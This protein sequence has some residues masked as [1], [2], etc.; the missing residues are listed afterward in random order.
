MIDDLQNQL[1]VAR[2][3][4]A[5]AQADALAKAQALALARRLGGKV[6]INTSNG[7]LVRWLLSQNN[8]NAHLPTSVKSR[9]SSHTINEPNLCILLV[10]C[11]PG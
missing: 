7:L 3:D 10:L 9:H 2:L 8:K 11:M 1:A 5:S 4:T 6:S